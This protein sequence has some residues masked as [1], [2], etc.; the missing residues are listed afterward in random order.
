MTTSIERIQ[1]IKLGLALTL[2]SSSFFLL[3]YFKE[4]L[5]YS[6]TKQGTWGGIGIFL[7]IIMVIFPMI[8]FLSK[9]IGKAIVGF[10]LVRKWI[11]R[12][13]YFEGKWID[14]VVDNGQSAIITVK[15]KNG[16][17]IVS[18]EYYNEN[19]EIL[20]DWSSYYCVVGDGV[21]EYSY[22][23]NYTDSQSKHTGHAQ[24]SFKSS[25]IWKIPRT[26]TG[27]F[28]DFDSYSNIKHKVEGERLSKKDRIQYNNGGLLGKRAV[29]TKWLK[30]VEG[31]RMKNSV[32][33]KKG[34][35][36]AAS[37][38]EVENNTSKAS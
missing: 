38:T 10:P 33:P 4:W 30:K 7:G 28:I 8:L 35:K 25:S 15:Y 31:I 32:V 9:Y 6:L 3:A 27:H 34:L 16:G 12:S 24:Y 20:G 29:V 18:G 5:N 37:N 26:F 1:K 19:Q 2:T 23:L 21:I 11:L 22:T 36:L 13:Q 14:I 17:Y